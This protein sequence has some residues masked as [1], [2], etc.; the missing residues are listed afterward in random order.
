MS[1]VIYADC[2][3]TDMFYAVPMRGSD[4]FFYIDLGQRK[5]VF[6]DHREIDVFKEENKNKAIEA[7]LLNPLL[8]KAS[9]LGDD[10]SLANKL[11]YIIFSEYG[12]LEAP[13]T[14]AAHFPLDMADY[15]RS[16]G[17]KLSVTDSLFPERAV[18]T[19]QEVEA[20]V[21][22]NKKTQEAFR[23]IETILKES[24][25][26]GERI[27]YKGQTLTSELIK[28]E[29]DQVLLA[30]DMINDAGLIIASGDQ[31]AIPH[32]EGHGPILPHQPII[33]DI[34]PKNRSTGF[35]ADITR[36][37]VKGEPSQEMVKIYE[38]V[39]KG[40]LAGIEAVAPGVAGGDIHKICSQVFLDAGYEVGDKGFIH[41]TGHGLGLNVHELP[42][43]KIEFD[44]VLEP[45]NVVTIEPGLYYKGRGSAR[46]ED[47]I[48][49]TESGSQNLTNYPKELI[50]T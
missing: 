23:L 47:D 8:A 36:T 35:Y 50:I 31:A 30:N 18:K 42:H 39:K 3:N 48:L 4:P 2:K 34:F 24:E 9:D 10:T 22:A 41:G 20:I 1:K 44:H 17:A 37:Y 28:A 5:Y 12:L 25:I 16:K 46:I 13:V 21:D 7:V 29:V 43:V 33:C 49:V 27:V 26:D 14:V 6:L 40:Q 32:H 15:L 19:K 38:T 45:G 11:A